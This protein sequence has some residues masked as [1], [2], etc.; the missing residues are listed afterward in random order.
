MAAPGVDD[1]DAVKMG[2][3][4]S[5]LFGSLIVYLF[6]NVSVITTAQPRV[7]IQRLGQKHRE[8]QC[9]GLV[10]LRHR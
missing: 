1:H 6:T 4:V 2:L 7:A 9:L 10:E 5:L 3:Q 8:D